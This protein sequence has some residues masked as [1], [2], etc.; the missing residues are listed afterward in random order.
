MS[1]ITMAKSITGEIP[2]VDL[3]LAKNKT[4]EALG[5]VYDESDWSFQTMFAG[6]L[7]PGLKANSQSQATHF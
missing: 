6:W 3:S 2:A 1:L 4:A 7:A 5:K